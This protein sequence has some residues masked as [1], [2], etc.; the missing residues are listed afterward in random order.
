[1][2]R[3]VGGGGAPPLRPGG[4]CAPCAPLPGLCLW[5]PAGAPP[6]VPVRGFAPGPATALRAVVLKLPG[7]G[8]PRTGWTGAPAPEIQPGRTM[9]PALQI[10]RGRALQPVR[11]LR[12]APAGR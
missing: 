6:L 8:N 5:T 11:R 9:R 10:R 1:M 4:G 2:L 12:T 3:A 7:G